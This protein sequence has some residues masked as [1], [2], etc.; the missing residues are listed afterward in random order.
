MD[1]QVSTIV[2]KASEIS[3]LWTSAV[4][5]QMKSTLNYDYFQ[6]DNFSA[7]KNSLSRCLL[8]VELW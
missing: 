8:I 6:S 3:L 4:L 5:L 2:A 1:Q 7:G